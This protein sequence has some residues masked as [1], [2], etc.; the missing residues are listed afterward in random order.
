MARK[1]TDRTDIVFGSTKTYTSSVG[2]S[3]AFRQWRASSH[4]KHLHGYALEFSATFEA[5]ELDDNNWTIDFGG[6]GD[7]RQWLEVMFDHTTLVAKDDPMFDLFVKATEGNAL[8]I[9]TVE[10]TGC[11]AIALLTFERLESWL[12]L[13]GHSPRVRLVKLEVREHAGNSA[14]VRL[15][16][17]NHRG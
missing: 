6:L 4:C 1:I 5:T 8:D 14:Y 3:T 17:F 2:L 15:S 16:D 12:D 13:K 9:R 11:E 7:F 10:N